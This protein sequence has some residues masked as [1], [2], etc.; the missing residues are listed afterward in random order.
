MNPKI[1]NVLADGGGGGLTARSTSTYHRP[2]N[3]RRRGGGKDAGGVE[4][5]LRAD[6]VR[7][8]VVVICEEKSPPPRRCFHE[9]D[10]LVVVNG[11]VV[12]C[13]AGGPQAAAVPLEEQRLLEGPVGG[14]GRLEEP[15]QVPIVRVVIALQ[16]EER[17]VEGLK[18]DD[19]EVAAARGR[20]GGIASPL[21]RRLRRGVPGQDAVRAVVVALE[22]VLRRR[23]HD[24]APGS[25]TGGPGGREGHCL[26]ALVALDA[27]QY[28]R[29]DHERGRK[30][31]AVGLV[32]DGNREG[33][34]AARF[35]GMVF[36]RHEER[37]AVVR[38]ALAV[39]RR[40][41]GASQRHAP[42]RRYPR[43]LAV[44][45]NVRIKQLAII[46]NKYKLVTVV[47]RPP[48][49][50][51]DLTQPRPRSILRIIKGI[52]HGKSL[53]AQ[54]RCGSDLKA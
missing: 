18:V 16:H 21:E 1:L 4:D 6:L 14:R 33:A 20:R 45:R 39:R 48:P 17:R 40:T 12:A 35:V 53:H 49:A 30:E 3:Q 44:D 43:R 41:V 5:E 46:T 47:S 54:R 15:D 7:V 34:R 9:A 26:K 52:I 50:G 8:P 13:A 51:G 19:A 38:D 23:E 11:E 42:R 2:G 24:V 28:V 22:R 10:R 29:V 32:E 25:G 37:V 27:C 31:A 36:R